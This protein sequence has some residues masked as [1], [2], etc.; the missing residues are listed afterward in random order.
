MRLTHNSRQAQYRSP[1]GAVPA[2]TSVMLRVQVY[3]TDPNCVNIT[4]R[5]WVDGKGET[6][7]PME[8]VGNGIFHVMLDCPEPEIKWYSFIVNEY[9]NPTVRLGAARGRTGGAGQVYRDG[10][11]P[12]FQITVYQPRTVR[13][14][15]YEQGIVYQIFPDRYRRDEDW[16]ERLEEAF[17]EPRNSADRRIVED[18]DTPP[19]YERNEDMSIKCWDFYG[20]SLKG[21]E[22]DLQRLYE[23]GVTAIYLNPIFEA[24]SNHRYDT[25]DYMRIDPALG[26]E[27]DF[28]HLCE[29]AEERGISII[30]DGVFN[31]TGDDSRYFNRYGTYEEPGAWQALEGEESEWADA[32]HLKDDGTYACWW[33]IENMPQLNPESPSVHEL[34]L[35]EDGVIRHWIRAGARGWRLDVADELTE[36]TIQEIRAATLD[37]KPDALVLGEVWEDA[38]NKISYG[39]PRHYLLGS[40]LD[41]AMNYPFRD[42]IIGFLTG[43]INAYDAAET[44]E[45]IRENYPPE[46]LACSLNLLSS[47]DRARILTVLAG[48]PDTSKMTE[49]EREEWRIPDDKM[50]LAKSRYWIAVLMQMTLPGVPSIYYGD[51]AGVQGL[52]DPCNRSTYPWGHEDKDMMV[53]TRNAIQLRRTMPFLIDGPIKAR[54]VNNDVLTYTRTDGKDQSITFVFNRSTMASHVITI[55]ATGDHAHD[56]LSGTDMLPDETGVYKLALYP[57]GSRAIYTHP[58]KRLQKPL[59]PGAGV[60]CHITS[61]PN[62]GGHPGTL[63]APAKRFVDHLSKMGMRYWQVLPVNPTDGYRS[64]YAGPSAFAGNIDLLDTDRGTLFLEFEELE[65]EGALDWDEEFLAFKE[66]NEAWLKPYCAFQA[67]KDS[68]NGASRHTWPEELSRYDEAILEDPEYRKL[69]RFNMYCQYRFDVQW[70]ELLDYAHERGVQIIGDI[71]MYVSDDSADAWSEPELFHLDD[72]GRATEVAGCPPDQFAKDGQIWGNPTYHW[73]VMERQDFR[74]WLARLGR[75]LDLYDYVRLDH[76]LGFQ[77][78]FSIPAGGTGAD[79]RWVKGPGYKLFQRAYEEFGP[80]PFIAEDLGII[81]PAV[82]ALTIECGFPGMDVLQFSDYDVRSDIR[83]HRGKVLYTSTH[84]T[85]TL[86]GFC[87]VSFCSPGDDEGA[88]LQA[89][90]IIE[91][92]LGSKANVV[93]MSLQD[94]LGLGDE[95]RMNVPGVAHGNWSWQA[96]E[97]DVAAAERRMRELLDQTGRSTHGKRG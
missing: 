53:M 87:A 40:E 51:E 81:T 82:R 2:G 65:R 39:K 3:D 55:P 20:G 14:T 91:R 84:D 11:V 30:L 28:E 46:A 32:F 85:A 48:M 73:R 10:D 64:P 23:M 57:L 50:G 25:G 54:A 63:G 95:A 34:L 78:Y 37:E 52:T 15:W 89:W 4:L 86:K 93:M 77:S 6:L 96:R 80:L 59:E 71:P 68:R 5:V 22:E 38:S 36:Q 62:E 31:H 12:S 61:L 21:I 74:W 7:I 94:V 35:G 41:S 88:L 56:I 97:S 42:M 16:H 44:I 29:A 67:I 58:H 1:Y 19:T 49:E 83:P 90:D 72:Q 27:E 17:E 60:I 75:M 8:H 76:F 43:T 92:A 9:G 70:H 18:W 47:H 13:P 69:A 33:G 79:G 45:S 24:T 66:R 26:T